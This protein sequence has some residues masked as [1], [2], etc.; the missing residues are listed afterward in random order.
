[1]SEALSSAQGSC[2][3][4]DDHPVICE[5][6]SSMLVAQGFTIIGTAVNL[7]DGF[8]LVRDQKP[9]VA[10][11]DIRLP[12][13]DGLELTRR[14][15][16]ASPGTA[17]VVYTGWRGPGALYEALDAGARG[18]VVKDSPLTDLVRAIGFVMRGGMFIDPMVAGELTMLRD[19]SDVE[20]LTARQVQVIRLLGDGF[21]D[22]EIAN[23]LCI[24]VETVRAHVK[25]AMARLQSHTRSQAVAEAMRRSYIS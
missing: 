25:R 23:Q 22:G 5:A 13:G 12:D 14:I 4:I 18:F 2:V 24:S 15:V 1:M 10:V 3:I 6:L 9:S 8:V 20:P 19:K 21:Q 11:I 17:V 7:Q 16:G